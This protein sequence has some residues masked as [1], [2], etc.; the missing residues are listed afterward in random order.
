MTTKR[1]N[2]GPDGRFLPGHKI[3]SP[4]AAY[5][6]RLHE[7]KQAFI[8]AVSPDD[9]H[10]ITRKLVAAAKAGDVA[11]IKVFFDRLFGKPKQDVEVSKRIQTSPIEELRRELGFPPSTPPQRLPRQS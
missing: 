11:A 3:K 2:R 1:S 5:S 9:V 10:A 4:G 6:H 8:D 7:H